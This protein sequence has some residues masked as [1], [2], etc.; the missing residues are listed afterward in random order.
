MADQQKPEKSPKDEDW[1]D[2]AEK[3]S[4]EPDP[5]RLVELVKELCD[6]LE[7]RE[8]VQKRMIKP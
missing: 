6:K 7:H 8:A 5:K 2:L 3:A 4:R 1:R